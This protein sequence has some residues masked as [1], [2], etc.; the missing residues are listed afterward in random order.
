M[1][2][3]GL[4]RYLRCQYFIMDPR[5]FWAERAHQSFDIHSFQKKSCQAN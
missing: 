1:F 3:H 5:I 2:S 4:A